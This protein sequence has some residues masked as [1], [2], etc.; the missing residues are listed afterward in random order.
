MDADG[1]TVTPEG[2]LPADAEPA[3]EAIVTT[4]VVTEADA[5]DSTEEFEA[6]P[7][8]VAPGK[9]TGL[10]DFEKVGLLALG[11]LAIGA[12]INGNKQVVSNSGDRVVVRQPDGTYQVYK[13]DNA[14]LREPGSTV[15]T[16]TFRR[17]NADH[18]GAHRW[19]PDRD[20]P[21]C[22]GPGFAACRL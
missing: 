21:R 2:T 9:K 22:D 10:S 18:C 6:A 12:M 11:A 20:D 4:E 5:R 13:D 17:V 7:V 8:T 15:R 14:L 1:E 19:Q 3:E 16:E